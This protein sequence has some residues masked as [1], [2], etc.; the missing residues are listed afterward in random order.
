MGEITKKI[1]VIMPVYNA[2]GYLQRSIRD[3]LRQT[4][5]YFELILVNDGSTDGSRQILQKF[6]E[7]DGRVRVLDQKNAGAGSARNTGFSYAAGEYAM[8][9]DADDRFSP[10]MLERAISEA[11]IA[12]T[13]ILIYDAGC[14]DAVSGEEVFSDWIVKRDKLPVKKVFRYLDMPEDIFTFSH[15]VAWNKLFRVSFLKENRLFFQEAPHT[16]DTLFMCM[17][18]VKAEKISFLDE[19]LLYYR[20][21]CVGSL[22]GGSVRQA[23]PLCVCQVLSAIQE[24]LIKA[25]IYDGVWKSFA[26]FSAEQLLWN[27]DVLEGEA[28]HS[29]FKEIKVRSL[30][31]YDII[32][33]GKEEFLREDLYDKTKRLQ[34][35][36]ER[37]YL[38]CLLTEKRRAISDL[39]RTIYRIQKKKWVFLDP[40]VPK[41][42]RIVLYG[43]GDIGR[44]YYAQFESTGEYALAAW[45]DRNYEMLARKGQ[46]VT[47]PE[48]IADLEYDFIVIA[49]MNRDAADDIRNLLIEKG[50]GEE[51]IVWPL[52]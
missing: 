40:K 28:F 24:Q 16:N 1:S 13:D 43:A 6:Q 14:F 33:L 39:G 44:D 45:V 9:L 19:K 22:T 17:A 15:N 11:E 21:N 47:P 36:G 3:L 4:Y 50:V 5:R 34:E 48:R 26:N 7:M 52:A 46:K 12:G 37:E 51:K 41:G 31:L 20:Q 38:F 35:G 27:L 32:R 49:V 18:L 29:L 8:F 25:R 10:T 2:E 42:S 23:Y 30:Q